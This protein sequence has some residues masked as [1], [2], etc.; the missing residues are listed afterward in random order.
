MTLCDT[1]AETMLAARTALTM[2]FS[3]AREA[4]ERFVLAGT[5]DAWY[6]AC[7]TNL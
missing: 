1:E 5:A 2:Q 3:V 4:G 6:A 7:L